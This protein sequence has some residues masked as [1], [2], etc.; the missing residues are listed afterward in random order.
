MLQRWDRLPA[1]LPQ[2][3]FDVSYETV[4]GKYVLLERDSMRPKTEAWLL[5]IYRYQGQRDQ[6]GHAVIF[7][8][9]MKIDESEANNSTVNL[10]RHPPFQSMAYIYIR[11]TNANTASFTSYSSRLVY[12]QCNT[13]LSKSQVLRSGQTVVPKPKLK[14]PYWSDQTVAWYRTHCTTR[15]GGAP[16][17]RCNINSLLV[18]IS[19]LLPP[20]RQTAIPTNQ[21]DRDSGFPLS[22]HVILKCQH[23]CLQG[24]RC[25]VPQISLV[26]NPSVRPLLLTSVRR[27]IFYLSHDILCGS[28]MLIRSVIVVPKFILHMTKER[29]NWL[30]QVDTYFGFLQTKQAL[31]R[32]VS[33]FDDTP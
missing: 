15:D 31:V 3:V 25:I 26:F 16:V 19:S 14:Q 9:H 7:T 27:R 21:P 20:E 24:E 5:S 10:T 2:S 8:L 23:I 13:D 32:E 33:P 1:G 6:R 22:S 11:H 4:F 12:L 28:D 29:K 17:P 18:D 30:C